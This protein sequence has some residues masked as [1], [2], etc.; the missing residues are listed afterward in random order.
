LDAYLTQAKPTLSVESSLRNAWPK[1][2]S[3]YGQHNLLQ[4]AEL[5]R[6]HVEDFHR[7]LLWHSYEGQLY[8]ANSVDQFA[9]RVRQVLRWAFD[10]G[11]VTPDPT[12]GLLLPRPVQPIPRLLNWSQVQQILAVPDRNTPIGW[13]DALIFQLLPETNLG[14]ICVVGLTVNSVAEL[15]LEDTTKE[16]LSDYLR[17]ARP[18]LGGSGEGLF[19]SRDGHPLTHHLAGLR[20]REAARQIGLDNLPSRLLRKSYLAMQN[21][22]HQRLQPFQP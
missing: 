18:A 19:F 9:R 22:V 12:F 2:L 20:L 1:F 7:E 13:R 21:Q 5:K 6:Q 15:Q 14:L 16:L 10:Q 17:E 8:K 11:L 4:I 3:F